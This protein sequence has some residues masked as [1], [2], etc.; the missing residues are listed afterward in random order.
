MKAQYRVNPDMMLELEGGNQKELFQA[1]A[2]AAEIF[3]T[4]WLMCG[5]CKDRNFKPRPVVR[6]N[7]EKQSFYELHCTN[8]QCGARFSFGQNKDMKSLFPQRNYTKSHP[9][10]G[11]PKPDGGWVKWKPGDDEHAGDEE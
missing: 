4:H 7:K 6:V 1:M 11:Q 5:C 9:K 8:P 2:Q 3:G 10:K